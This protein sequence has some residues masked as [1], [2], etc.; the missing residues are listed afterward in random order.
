MA[1]MNYANECRIK[2]EYYTQQTNN[3]TAR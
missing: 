2:D 3:V 1:K